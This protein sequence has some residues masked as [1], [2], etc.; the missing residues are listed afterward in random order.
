ME[1]V[2]KELEQKGHNKALSGDERIQALEKEVRKDTRTAR[3]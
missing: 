1:E 2:G 3:I